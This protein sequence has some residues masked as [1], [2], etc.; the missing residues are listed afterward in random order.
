M[1]VYSVIIAGAMVS[2]F[3]VGVCLGAD[4]KATAKPS[5]QP[6]ASVQAQKAQPAQPVPAQEAGVPKG[7]KDMTKEDIL[8]RITQLFGANPN[9]TKIVPSIEAAK[10]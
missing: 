1:K 7:V 3:M 5:A 2:V 8:K 9:L 4:V 6:A 10:D